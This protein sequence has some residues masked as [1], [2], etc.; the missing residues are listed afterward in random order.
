MTE[1]IVDSWDLHA[2]TYSR[3]AAPCTGYLA[4]SLFL[5]VAGRLAPAAR[6]LDVACGNGELS[7][8]AVLHAMHT[9]ETADNHGHLTAV[10][11]SPAMVDRTRSQLAAIANDPVAFSRPRSGGVQSTRS[12]RGFRWSRSSRHSPPGSA[13]MRPELGGSSRSV[14]GLMPLLRGSSNLS[15]P[16]RVARRRASCAKTPASIFFRTG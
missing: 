6:V 11:F 2:D 7:R 3:I 15:P 4:Q 10:D 9:A 5:H 8:A 13:T 12:S 14:R 16:S 1:P